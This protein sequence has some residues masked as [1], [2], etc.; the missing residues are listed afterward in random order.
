[1]DFF[2]IS[3]QFGD[4]L[5]SIP[6]C[7]RGA[8]KGFACFLNIPIQDSAI[9]MKASANWMCIQ[10]NGGPRGRAPINCMKLTA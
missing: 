2:A 10:T 4:R 1:M 7:N 5:V 8:M 3:R 6:E 9:Q